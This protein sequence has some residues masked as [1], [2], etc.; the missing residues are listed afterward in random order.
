M[1]T[2]SRPCSSPTPP[3]PLQPSRWAT[4]ARDTCLPA[5]ARVPQPCLSFP[6]SWKWRVSDNGIPRP[7]R[8]GVVWNGSSGRLVYKSR[9]VYRRVSTA[10]SHRKIVSSTASQLRTRGRYLF[11]VLGS[12]EQLNSFLFCWYNHGRSYTGEAVTTA[13]VLAG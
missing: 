9:A 6:T 7:W 11:F 2:S 1:T 10:L 4:Q 12:V 3:S 8:W 13:G 5:T